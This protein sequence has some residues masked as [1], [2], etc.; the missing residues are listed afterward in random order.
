MLVSDCDILRL[1]YAA[2]T[3]ENL[4]RKNHPDLCFGSVR[5]LHLVNGGGFWRTGIYREHCRMPTA[6]IP[7]SG[8]PYVQ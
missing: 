4:G 1:H 6:C 3:Q 2:G 7:D 8:I 5:R